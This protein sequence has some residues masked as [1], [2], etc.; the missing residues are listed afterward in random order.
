MSEQ[1]ESKR[2][3]HSI[4]VIHGEGK[5]EHWTK[6]G[7]AWQ[8]KDQKGFSLVFDAYPAG[9]GRVVLRLIE[10]DASQTETGNGG[11]Q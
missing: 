3:T 5:K 1:Q 7:A 8:H 9:N 6:I 4:H 10:K 11:Q 2:P